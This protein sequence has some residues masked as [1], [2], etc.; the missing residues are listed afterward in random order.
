MIKINFKISD[1]ERSEKYI[2]F[3]IELF[4]IYMSQYGEINVI[5]KI[6]KIY[7]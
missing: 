2:S 4:F 5:F 6:K 3:I 1:F 7:L